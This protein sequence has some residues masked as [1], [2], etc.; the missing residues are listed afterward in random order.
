MDP[1]V[2][3]SG[4]LGSPLYWDEMRAA[5]TFALGIP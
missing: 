3:G 2:D 1:M 5:E 4:F